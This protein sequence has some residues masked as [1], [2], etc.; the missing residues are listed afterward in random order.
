MYV[1]VLHS[2]FTD[3]N[4]LKKLGLTIHPVHRMRQYDI[5]DAP[6]V[7]LEKRYEGLWSRTS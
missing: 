3:K 2:E 7:G 6:G 5:G 1:Y 4:G